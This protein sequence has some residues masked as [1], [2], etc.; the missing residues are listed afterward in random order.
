[1]ICLKLS[2]REIGEYRVPRC[3]HDTKF[4]FGKLSKFLYKYSLKTNKGVCQ[5]KW[6]FDR[7]I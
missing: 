5:I 6:D 1:M 3:E 2:L 4:Q 7:D